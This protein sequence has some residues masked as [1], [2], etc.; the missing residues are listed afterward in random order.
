L[1]TILKGKEVMCMVG[2][3]DSGGTLEPDVYPLGH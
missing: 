2:E 1:E 3:R